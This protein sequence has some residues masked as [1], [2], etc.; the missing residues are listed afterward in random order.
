MMCGGTGNRASSL[1]TVCQAYDLGE[2]LPRCEMNEVE[3]E[4]VEPSRR[5]REETPPEVT[6]LE[7]DLPPIGAAHELLRIEQKTSCIWGLSEPGN[8]TSTRSSAPR[9]RKP[10]PLLFAFEAGPCRFRLN[11]YLQCSLSPECSTSL[12]YRSSSRAFSSRPGNRTTGTGTLRL[13]TFGSPYV[14]FS[15]R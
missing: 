7:L 9:N 11:R 4:L 10:S 6:D 8:E 1:R 3:M 13:A 12:S 5:L 15:R 14:L 2:S